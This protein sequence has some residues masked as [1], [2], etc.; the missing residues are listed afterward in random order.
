MCSVYLVCNYF[1][2]HSRLKGE[3]A[4][5]N[6]AKDRREQTNK[7]VGNGWVN[8]RQERCETLNH[9]VRNDNKSDGSQRITK[10]LYTPMQIRLGKHNMPRHDKS[11][12]ETNRKRHQPSSN[13][14][15]YFNVAK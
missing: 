4:L 5:S 8:R 1:F 11:G 6:V 2:F 14:G 12:R 9:Q 7:C 13:L 10:K 15:S 3:S